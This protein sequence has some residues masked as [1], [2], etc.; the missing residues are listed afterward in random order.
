MLKINDRQLSHQNK[1]H[2]DNNSTCQQTIRHRS[3]DLEISNFVFAPLSETRD[4]QTNKHDYVF[5]HCAWAQISGLWDVHGAKHS[6]PGQHREAS[7]G[8]RGS[9]C[10]LSGDPFDPRYFWFNI[11]QWRILDMDPHVFWWSFQWYRR[12]FCN[13]TGSIQI[14]AHFVKKNCENARD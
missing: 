6:P 7:L 3:H 11:I 1:Q 14:L 5:H 12:L 4:Q 9:S 13:F 10:L 8:N 2:T